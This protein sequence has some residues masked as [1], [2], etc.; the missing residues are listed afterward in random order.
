MVVGGKQASGLP[1]GGQGRPCVKP[2]GIYLHIP[3]CEHKCHY[4]DF[5]SVTTASRQEAFMAAMMTEIELRREPDWSVDS[6]YFGGGTPS[7]LPPDFYARVL[8]A[9]QTAF[10]LEADIEITLEANPGTIDL[11]GLTDYRGAG[12]NRLNL[13]LQ[14]FNDR[15]LRF[16]GRIHT[17]AQAR[18][19]VEMARRAGFDNLG[20]D[21]IYGLPGQTRR[22]WQADLER[23]L[24]RAPEHLACY[25]LTYE[26]DTP[27]WQD[28]LH[29]GHRPAGEAETAALF[30]T[31]V[32]VLCA[33]GFEH[34]EISNFA[35]ARQ[36]RSR[37]NS[38]YWARTPYAGF[39]PA[40]H[41]F[42]GA[43]RSWNTADLAD[44]MEKLGQ[45]LWPEAGYEE[46]DEVQQMIETVFLG[47]R[48]AAGVDL[49]A[50]TR[51]FGQPLET[52]AAA[53]I[54]PLVDA[55]YLRLTPDRLAPTVKGMR[56]HDSISA[57]M[58]GVF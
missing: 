34:Y 18:N 12:I 49:S 2:A 11:A 13:G 26:Q 44:Y 40:A 28:R 32:D 20:L 17:A 53:V 39:G 24:A 36:W 46:L 50:F 25:M 23:S 57:R 14:S 7:L 1:H 48:L 47:L 30:Q 8:A 27:L 21:M 52:R 6:I 10:H 31:S 37:H 22:A 3:F 29:G 56:L 15:H 54:Q 45:G 42:R 51:R 4:C 55:G 19:A 58:I 38:K 35:A 33:A 43:R 41:S 5:Y 16:L 9:L